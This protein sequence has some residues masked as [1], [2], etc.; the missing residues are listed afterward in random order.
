MECVE[1][2]GEGV[3]EPRHESTGQTTYREETY[4]AERADENRNGKTTRV[5][6]LKFRARLLL[7]YV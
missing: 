7:L 6:Q 4:R 2:G 5:T 3:L 1:G